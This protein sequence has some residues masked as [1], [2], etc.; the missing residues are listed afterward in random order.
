MKMEQELEKE[1]ADRL[2]RKPSRI[3]AGLMKIKNGRLSLTR[4]GSLHIG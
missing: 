1:L 2:L 4:E 3:S